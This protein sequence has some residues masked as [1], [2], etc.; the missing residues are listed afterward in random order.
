MCSPKTI[1][2][3]GL[4]FDIIGVVLVYLYGL[5]NTSSKYEF[6]SDLDKEKSLK[7]LSTAGLI[8]IGIGFFLQLI[9]NY[10]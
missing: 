4:V 2:S 5:P 10:L 9:S 8:L 6:E 7:R 3:I 1:N